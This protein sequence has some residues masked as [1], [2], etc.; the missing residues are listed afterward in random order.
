MGGGR[1]AVVEVIQ[2]NISM[3]VIASGNFFITF[4]YL[5]VFCPKRRYNIS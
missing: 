5:S 2:L 4:C 1:R 3:F